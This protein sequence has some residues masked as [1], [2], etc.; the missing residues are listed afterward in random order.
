M[1]HE[2]HEVSTTSSCA[3]QH[4]SSTQHK[5]DDCVSLG[6]CKV[7][8]D[9]G[10]E[11]KCSQETLV[12]DRESHTGKGLGPRQGVRRRA[13]P[14]SWPHPEARGLGVACVMSVIGSGQAS[15]EPATVF[16]SSPETRLEE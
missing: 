16:C 11:G 1:D 2:L 4:H 3:H 10:L 15:S 14:Q 8:P 12:T 6:F 7:T 13:A 5:V 9:Q